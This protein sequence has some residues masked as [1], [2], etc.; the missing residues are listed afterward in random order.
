MKT[1]SLNKIYLG[2]VSLL[3]ILSVIF[4]SLAIFE[5]YRDFERETVKIKQEFIQKTNQKLQLTAHKIDQILKISPNNYIQILNIILDKSIY[6]EIKKN[7]KTIFIHSNP[8]KKP[9]SYTLNDNNFII[10]LQDSFSKIEKL[11][12]EKKKALIH[13]LTK[14]M[15]NF[16]T[17]AFIIYMSALGGFYLLNEFLKEEINIFVKFF[18]KAYQEHIYIKFSDIKIKEFLNIAVYVNKMLKEINS[19]NKKLER[20]NLTLEEKVRQKTRKLQNLIN[21][22]ENFIK[23]A[24]H[25]INTPLA[26]ILTSLNFLDK[27][28]KNVQRIESAVLMINNIYADL[29]F[30]LKYKHKDYPLQIINIKDVL[31]ERIQFFETI[32]NAKK[33]K[34]EYEINDFNVCINKEEL[35]RIIDN[36]LSNAIKYSIPNSTVK[37]KTGNNTLIFENK[38]N[39]INNIDKFFEPFYKEH[40]NTSGFGLGLYLVNEICKKYNIKVTISHKDNIIMFEYQF[41]ECNENSLG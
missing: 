41:K 1:L 36:N 30:V 15:L 21:E 23:T 34:F 7:N 29:S 18:Q 16:L 12:K 19:Q 13:K 20:L 32:A 9:I 14:T 28:D 31:T 40:E 17:L 39:E 2:G 22:Q 35:I 5:E 10:T 38:T 33:L 6:V 11:I 26:I 24:I 25:E 37:I 3:F 4:T 27:N 8:P